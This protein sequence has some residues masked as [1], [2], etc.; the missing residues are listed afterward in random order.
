MVVAILSIFNGRCLAIQ[1]AQVCDVYLD[2]SNHGAGF[3]YASDWGYTDWA[4]DMSGMSEAHINNKEIMAAVLVARRWTPSW[5][6]S[7]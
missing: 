3:V 2:A 4:A 1:A 5:A 7:H 6:N